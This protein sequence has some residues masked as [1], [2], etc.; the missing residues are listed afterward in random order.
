MDLDIRPLDKKI[1]APPWAERKD[2]GGNDR[3]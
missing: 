2:N 3:W 1:F